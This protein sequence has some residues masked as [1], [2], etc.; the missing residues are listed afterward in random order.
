MQKSLRINL[1]LPVRLLH[2]SNPEVGTELSLFIKWAVQR[3]D[4][5]EK[6][7]HAAVQI[8]G[9]EERRTVPATDIKNAKAAREAAGCNVEKVHLGPLQFNAMRGVKQDS[10][11]PLSGW[12]RIALSLGPIVGSMRQLPRADRYK[13]YRG[14]TKSMETQ[15]GV[16]SILLATPLKLNGA[17]TRNRTR[18][19][20]IF[21]PF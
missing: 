20:R 14:C 8:L 19:T 21:S 11:A 9:N 2:S 15:K 5:N 7:I 10:R 13:L 4:D 1:T 18:D 3:L 17:E 12:N 16:A 6:S